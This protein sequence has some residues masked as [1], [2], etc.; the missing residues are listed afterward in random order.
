MRVLLPYGHVHM[1]YWAPNVVKCMG[2]E[3]GDV[4]DDC[5]QRAGAR[6]LH[7]WCHWDYYIILVPNVKGVLVGV[8]HRSWYVQRAQSFCLSILF[9][10]II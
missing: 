9:W 3:G 1:H 6:A 4:R 2:E 8:V 5:H 7:W 10:I